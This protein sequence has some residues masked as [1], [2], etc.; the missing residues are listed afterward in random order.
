MERFREVGI[1]IVVVALAL[2]FGALEPSF[3]S[4]S[5]LES[6]AVDISILAIVACGQTLIILARHIDL[7][8]GSVLGL[9]AMCCGLALRADE[10]LSL[11]VVLAI[12]VGVGAT[13]GLFNGL[14]VSLGRVPAIITTLGTLAIVRG[15]IFVV[16]DSRQIDPQS[17]PQR[18]TSLAVDSP[19]GV[20]WLLLIAIAVALVTAWLLRM[21]STG[22]MIFAIGSNPEAAEARGLPVKRLTL[23]IF[24]ACGALAGLGGMM[25]VARF[26]T[27]NPADV[28]YGFELG[29]IA[30]VVIGGTNVFG[31]R[32]SIAGTVLGCLLVGVIANG[33]TVVGVSQ[34]W[35]GAIQGAI[36][37]F[38]VVVDS[39]VRRRAERPRHVV[40]PEVAR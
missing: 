8:V 39:Q 35:Q 10:G 36:I 37:L 1:A 31:G 22:R 14:L 13:A 32:G 23:G 9:S 15:I 38:A 16:S 18:V 20:P 30:A 26:G 12:A 34:F 29:V 21:T 28:G 40:V 7:S 4:A 27:V 19:F 11:V 5:N 25:Y 17:I 24:V 33:L 2:L 6:I 3:L